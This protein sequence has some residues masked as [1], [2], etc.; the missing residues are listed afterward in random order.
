MHLACRTDLLSEPPD[1]RDWPGAQRLLR[2]AVE[3][4][5]H[6]GGGLPLRWE[7]GAGW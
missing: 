6:V 2:F 3:Q 5:V 1:A 7:R 4:T